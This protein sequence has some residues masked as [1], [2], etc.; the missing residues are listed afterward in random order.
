MFF[1]YHP[2]GLKKKFE[3]KGITNELI[4]KIVNW[5]VYKIQ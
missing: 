5:L 1:H 4:K 2:G 3:E